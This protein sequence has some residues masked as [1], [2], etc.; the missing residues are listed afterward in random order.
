MNLGQAYTH[1]LDYLAANEP[2][3]ADVER[4]RKMITKKADRLRVAQEARRRSTL[5]YCGCHNKSEG[6]LVCFMCWAEMPE[7]LRL[8]FRD[9]SIQGEERRSIVREIV[10]RSRGE[11]DG[12]I[13]KEQCAKCGCGMH[14]EFARPLKI[15]GVLR[16]VCPPC[17][18]Q[19]E[20]SLPS[21]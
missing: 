12:D 18:E 4:A 10:A 9:Q 8:R 6:L 11:A 2:L 20:P 1:L 3:P 21:R 15:D 16:A 13:E 19:A 14:R 17:K 5:C 7:E